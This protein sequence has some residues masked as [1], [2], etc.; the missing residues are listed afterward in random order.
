MSFFPFFRVWT[1]IPQTVSLNPSNH[2]LRRGGSRF[3]RFQTFKS[4]PPHVDASTDRPSLVAVPSMPPSGVETLVLNGTS[5]V[6]TWQ[7]PPPASVHGRLA[8]FSLFVVEN[9]S[10]LRSNIS[11]GGEQ[12]SAAFHNLTF[13][14]SYS[15]SVAAN[16]K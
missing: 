2:P 5:A 15:A 7:P 3:S 13:G 1:R 6:V 4:V 11:V 9:G 16:T 12:R 14:A 8:S 10:L